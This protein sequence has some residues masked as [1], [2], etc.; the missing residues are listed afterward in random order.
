MIIFNSRNMY[1]NLS[2]SRGMS[3]K[4]NII[5]EMSI[6]VFE[7]AIMRDVIWIFL[8]LIFSIHASF[9]YQCYIVIYSDKSEYKAVFIQL[10]AHQFS[11]LCMVYNMYDNYQRVFMWN[12]NK[13]YSSFSAL[14]YIFYLIIIIFFLRKR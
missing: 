10:V 5:L 1:I 6:K 2:L 13:S 8:V 9:R 11:S 12:L 4:S 7:L 14:K 3:L